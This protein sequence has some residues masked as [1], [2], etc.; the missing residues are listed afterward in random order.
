PGHGVTRDDMADVMINQLD[1]PDLSVVP[2]QARHSPA[3]RTPKNPL[4]TLGALGVLAVSEKTLLVGVRPPSSRGLV[5]C[6]APSRS[7]LGF[8]YLHCE[9][10]TPRESS[11]IARVF[12]PSR[13]ARK[14]R[15]GHAMLGFL[16]HSR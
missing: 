1:A 8:G 11:R 9:G 14:G 16:T 10:R 7:P 4:A 12:A 2:R 13:P 6:E 3:V 15:R 5:A